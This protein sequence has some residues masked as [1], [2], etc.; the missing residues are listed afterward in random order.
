[1]LASPSWWPIRSPPK[2]QR[3]CFIEDVVLTPDEHSSIL[4]RGAGSRNGSFRRILMNNS[5]ARTS[6]G[7]APIQNEIV[8][9]PTQP[10]DRVF[11]QY[12][13]VRAVAD[14]RGERRDWGAAAI[15][16]FVDPAR[17]APYA[18]APTASAAPREPLEIYSVSGGARQGG[19]HLQ[20][21]YGIGV[22]GLHVPICSLL[23][24][25]Q[26]NAVADLQDRR[27]TLNAAGSTVERDG[28]SIPVGH[29]GRTCPVS[30]APRATCERVCAAAT[31][32]PYSRV[33]SNR[34]RSAEQGRREGQF[35]ERPERVRRTL[36]LCER[37]QREASP[38]GR[39]SR[40]QAF[41]I[42]ISRWDDTVTIAIFN[43]S[44][45]RIAAR[46]PAH[47]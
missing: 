6:S 13:R 33:E 10:R 5:F 9:I 14:E 23:G 34:R 4:K 36:A 28:H 32:Q 21:A 47:C 42:G 45:R 7:I 17:W 44:H 12:R 2:P 41:R 16:K 38:P 22:Q 19:H 11:H 15:R 46:L 29:E 3:R 24:D 8:K 35:P 18:V 1:M 40:R 25:R 30:T 37:A 31:L 43:V 27:T 26:K 20:N 39:R